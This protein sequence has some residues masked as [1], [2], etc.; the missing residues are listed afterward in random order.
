M[1]IKIKPFVSILLVVLFCLA[2]C[3]NTAYTVTDDD[4]IGWWSFD[5]R[6]IGRDEDPLFFYVEINANGDVRYFGEDGREQGSG[7][8]GYNDEKELHFITIY[9]TEHNV[10][11]GEEEGVRYI[12]VDSAD[13]FTY[14]QGM[15]EVV[16]TATQSP[17]PQ[18]ALQAESKLTA[19]YAHSE[20][21]PVGMW[22]LENESELPFEKIEILSENDAN[23]DN[24][25]CLDSESTVLDV[26]TFDYDTVQGFQAGAPVVIISF[27]NTGIYASYFS[28]DGNMMFL[29]VAADWGI[30]KEEAEIFSFRRQETL[31]GA[32]DEDVSP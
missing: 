11:V 10:Y 22:I 19:S 18:S 26:G 12:S 28:E 3:A 14:S 24:I 8:L 27:P 30:N 4:F 32:L 1:S 7:I 9:G 2:G 23:D 16:A 20:H 31:E 29:A 13:H 6:E 5:L 15:P 25:L 17:S 21:S